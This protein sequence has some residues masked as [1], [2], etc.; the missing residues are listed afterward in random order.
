MNPLTQASSN[1]EGIAYVISRMDWYWHLADLLLEENQGVQRSQGLQE[2]LEQNL[3][4]LYAR[5]LEYQMKSIITYHRRSG[6]VFA[7]DL[8]K[9]DDWEGELT[10][11]KEM[12]EVLRQ[13][14]AQFSTHEIRDQLQSIAKKAESQINSLHN[15]LTSIQE[16]TARS[17]EEKK[18]AADNACLR[19]LYLTNPSDDKVHLEDAEGGLFIGSYRWILENATYQQWCD[20]PEVRLLWIEG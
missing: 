3:V 17:L 6:I 10:T 2:Q 16:Q 14:V 19:D 11:I 15:I 18:S 12:E 7:R 5:L 20:D 8:V 4:D 1:R 9:W 13:G